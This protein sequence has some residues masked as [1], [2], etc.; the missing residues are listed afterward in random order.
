MNT[1]AP[2][3]ASSTAAR[4]CSALATGT[5]RTSAGTARLTGPLTS[6]TSAPLAHR[7]APGVTHLSRAD[8]GDAAHRVD[9][10]EGGP[11]GHHHLASGQYLGHE[12]AFEAFEQL[13]RL[14]HAPHADLATGLVASGRAEHRDTVAADQGDVALR[15]RRLPH[16]PV[17]RRRHDQ[18]HIA[19]QRQGA[20]QIIR[21][22]LRHAGD[23]VRCGRRDE[24]GVGVTPEIDVRHVVGH[25][26]I[27]QVGPHRVARQRL[28]SDRGH[29]TRA[30]LAQHHMHIGTGLD[31][32]A[33]QLRCL[34][35][36]DATADPENYPAT[37]QHS[38]DNHL[39][40]T[41]MPIE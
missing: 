34:V 1:C 29:E 32:Q 10:L 19:R 8:V 36:R 31:Q 14:E 9:R 13:L 38:H 15:R 39:Y 6:T 24:D 12:K 33:H 30:A 4:I 40:S 21:A 7:R 20:E 11:R 22:P 17:H 35:C 28:E 41:L 23:E 18:R 26:R 27:P 3:S 37:L 25:T 2:G 5:Q 16:L